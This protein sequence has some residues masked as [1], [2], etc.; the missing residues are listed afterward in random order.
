MEEFQPSTEM[1]PSPEP[2]AEPA[3]SA[4]PAEMIE[5]PAVPAET[6]AP[7]SSPPPAA[8]F[9]DA[10]AAVRPDPSARFRAE[11]DRY[12]TQ[13]LTMHQQREL[14]Q[15][16]EH[17]PEAVIPSMDAL[18]EDYRKLRCAGVNTIA[19]YEAVKQARG[20][21]VRR[22][23]PD[24]GAVGGD[25]PREKEYYTPDEVDRLT[26]SQLD[27]PRIMERVMQSM[28]RWKK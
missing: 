5:E 22:M 4:D 12:R 21:G 11:A 28:R 14:Q 26:P 25:G 15:I 3:G 10:Q 7:P 17:D 1:S 19:A 23:P 13:L 2:V 6:A 8:A 27:D 24:T 20:A 16:R 18:G 9:H